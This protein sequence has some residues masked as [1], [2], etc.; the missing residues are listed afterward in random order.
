MLFCDQ[1]EYQ[2]EI[3]ITIIIL[4]KDFLPPWYLPLHYGAWL[5]EG[6]YPHLLNIGINL[7]VFSFPN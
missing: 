4:L 1:D 2:L 7:V 6:V 3:T 5:L